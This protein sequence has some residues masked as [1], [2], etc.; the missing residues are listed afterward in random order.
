M[1]I[2][3]WA[4]FVCA[5]LSMVLG[6]VWYGPLLGKAW[7]RIVG[8][9]DMDIVK[10]KEMQKRAMPL[11]F[12][13]FALVLVQLFIL[14]HLTGDSIASGILS[15]LLIWIGFILPTV[16]AACMWTNE[17]RKVAW[18]RFGIQAGYQLVL[19]IVFGFVLG[20]WI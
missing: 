6:F 18:A 12:I 19:F 4:I 13:Q 15:A 20:L 5:V 1:G 10:R 14:A 8:A 9:T 17:P 2:N 7:L 3:Y 11:Y 16:A